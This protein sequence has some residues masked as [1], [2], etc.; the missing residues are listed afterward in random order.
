MYNLKLT[1]EQAK[2]L[3]IVTGS[4]SGDKGSR[5]VYDM[6]QSQFGGV[7]PPDPLLDEQLGT[8]TVT[9]SL[10]RQL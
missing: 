6:L 8:I 2:M 9:D 10:I 1:E 5:G 7:Y 3:L 4:M